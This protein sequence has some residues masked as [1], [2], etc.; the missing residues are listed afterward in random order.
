MTESSSPKPMPRPVPRPGHPQVVKPTLGGS[1]AAEAAAWGRVD[2]EGNVWLR[3]KDGEKVV[4]QYAAQGSKDDALAIY[5]RRYLDLKAQLTLIEARISTVNPE[6]TIAALKSFDEQLIEPAAVGDIEA[7]RS[8]SQ[9]LTEKAKELRKEF[10]AKRE[11]EKVEALAKREQIVERAEQI[12]AS[13]TSP[14]N[15]RDARAEL[16]SLMDKWKASQKEGPRIDKAVGD[17]LWSR[18]SAARKTFENARRAYF[19]DLSKHQA[20]VVAVKEALIAQAET[21][22]TSTDWRKT[23]NDMRRLMDEWK[24]AGRAAKRD[25]D[26]LWA[27][28]VAAREVFF[29]ARTQHGE[30]L[31]Q[32]H[33]ANL[34]EKLK[35][36][37]EAEALLPVQNTDTARTALRGILE[38]WENI[39]PVSRSQYEKVEERLKRVEDEIKKAEDEQWRRTDPEKQQRSTGMAAQLEALIAELEEE[40]ADAQSKGDEKKVKELIEAKEAREAWLSQVTKD[41]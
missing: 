4:G 38:K 35:L 21:L 13:V 24:E 10:A 30:A 40:I 34:E 33:S 9:A 36:L 41:L 31:D 5:V 7:L 1:D 16:T 12:A 29:S 28:F 25:D 2:D 14:I 19:Q 20:R 39:G 17:K 22:A 3:S 26:K 8:S 27:R 11:A 18:F 23:S 6:E 37:E 32:Q 15:W